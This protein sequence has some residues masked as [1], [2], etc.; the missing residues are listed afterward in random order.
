MM[1]NAE[2]QLRDWKTVIILKEEISFCMGKLSDALTGNS[3]QDMCTAIV[4][5][6]LDEQHDSAAEWKDVTSDRTAAEHFIEISAY[7]IRLLSDIYGTKQ[8]NENNEQISKSQYKAA[9][10]AAKNPIMKIY[11][12]RKPSK[13]AA[14]AKE[15]VQMMA[16]LPG[17]VQQKWAVFAYNGLMNIGGIYKNR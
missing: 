15:V 4:W 12:G 8:F 13:F 1:Q 2:P 7:W 5:N 16:A 10:K 3:A 17:P 14:T 6:L 11:F 9:V